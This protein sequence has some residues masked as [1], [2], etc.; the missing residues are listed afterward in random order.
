M[1]TVRATNW[2]LIVSAVTTTRA[3]AVTSFIVAACLARTTFVSRVSTIDVS[4][5]L[6]FLTVS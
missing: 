3:P 5:P 1:S 4:T 6:T 2:V